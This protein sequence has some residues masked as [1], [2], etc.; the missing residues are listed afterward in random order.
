[1]E[2]SSFDDSAIMIMFFYWSSADNIGIRLDIEQRIEL[3]IVVGIGDV[4]E[5]V[6]LMIWLNGGITAEVSK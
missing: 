4:R 5:Y 3:E 1:M 2:D 6:A